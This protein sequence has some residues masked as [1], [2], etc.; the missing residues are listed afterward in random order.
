M[1]LFPVY[2]KFLNFFDFYD[3]SKKIKRIIKIKKTKFYSIFFK[4][5]KFLLPM[6]K[7]RKIGH[8]FRDFV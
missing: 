2:V 7:K 5:N 6:Q 1:L 4:K 8:F 3:V